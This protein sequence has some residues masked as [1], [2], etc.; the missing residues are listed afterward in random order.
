[1]DIDMKITRFRV[2]LKPVARTDAIK[3]FVTW[4][5]NTDIGEI[6]IA[7]GTIKEK[8]FGKFNKILLS[9]DAPAY[10]TRMGYMKVLFIN[11]KD[12]FKK[13]CDFTIDEYYRETGETRDDI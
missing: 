11:N 2:E 3:A 8:T 6:K 5:F 12:F 9:Y 4:Y 10:K 7:G 13:L 1:M